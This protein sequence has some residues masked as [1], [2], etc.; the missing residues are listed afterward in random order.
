[1]LISLFRYINW[2]I[3]RVK[4][5]VFREV[6]DRKKP[7]P[8]DGEPAAKKAKGEDET[9]TVKKVYHIVT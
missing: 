9:K 7:P 4:H 8:A 1:M 3:L 5:F 2:F 6:A